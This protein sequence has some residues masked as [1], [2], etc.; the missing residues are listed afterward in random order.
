M[1][2]N[3]KNIFL[4]DGAGALLSAILTGVL[5][6]LY[7]DL[8]GL[9]V[10][11]LYILALFPL[12]YAVYSFSCYFFAEKQNPVFLKIIM[13]AN[14]FYCFVSGVVIFSSSELTFWG[15]SFFIAEIVVILVVIALE[16][17]IYLK[18]FSHRKMN[19]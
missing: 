16:R 15:H 14:L 1:K 2:L 12:M 19:S 18:S 8:L 9:S 7:A 3:E 10:G 6:P 5:L 11:V 4:F 17:K 13:S